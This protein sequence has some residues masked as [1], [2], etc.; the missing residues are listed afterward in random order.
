[1]AETKRL[2]ILLSCYSCGPDRG[3]EPGVGWNAALALAELHE[4]HV[5][6]TS[7]FQSEIEEKIKNKEI[8][9]SLYFHF[10]EFP[11]CRKIWPHANGI[12][13]R[14]HYLL[15]QRFA[16]STVKRL[17]KTF[18]FDS[19]Q[20]LTFV[21]YW[22]ASCLV[23][24]GIP[25]IFGPVGGAEYSPSQL[26][27]GYSLFGKLFEVIRGFSRRL[28]ES[29]PRV[30]R[31]LRNASLVLATTQLTLTRC[32]HLGVK[33]E[34]IQVFGESGLSNSEFEKLKTIPLPGKPLCFFG[35]GRLV[36]LKG[37]NLALR[38]FARANIPDSR[39][40]LIG[41]GVEEKRLREL[42][43]ELGIADKVE[44]TGFLPREQALSYLGQGH[45]MVHPSHHDSGGWAC[46]EA[47]ATG[48]PVVCLD[49]GGPSTQVTEEVGY[50]IPIGSEDKVIDGFAK[51]MISLSDADTLLSKSEHAKTHIASHYLWTTKVEFYSKIHQQI[52]AHARKKQV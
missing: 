48:R 22:S 47:M 41:G 28:G 44:I 40:L 39:F 27:R 23:D 11:I 50:K 21:R 2:R 31:T 38:A 30:K 32:L 24:S 7:E 15:W 33:P 25:Y 14:I 42:A 45:V 12:F 17:H 3:S 43:K 13:I 26:A 37:Y 1:M 29:S 10:F 16:S 18:A 51:A 20:H 6:T 8:P 34:N 46:I 49:W 5:L 4:V 52:Y 9:E 36:P 19:A 35:L